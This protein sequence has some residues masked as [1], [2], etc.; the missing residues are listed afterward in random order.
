MNGSNQVLGMGWLPDYP[1]FRD[2]TIEEK[3]IKPSL[4]ALGQRPIVKM[5]SDV[6]V[7]KAPSTAIPDNA[8]PLV[9]PRAICP[10]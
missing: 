2:Y 3:D 9:H 10:P 6:W 8:A 7:N 5:L 4:K 1:D